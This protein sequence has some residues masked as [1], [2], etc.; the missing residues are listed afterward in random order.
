MIWV[1]HL[2]SLYLL[3]EAMSPVLHV[4]GCRTLPGSDV[5]GRCR[6]GFPFLVVFVAVHLV[7]FVVQSFSI[8]WCPFWV[9]SYQFL[10]PSFLPIPDRGSRDQK[11]TGY[12]IRNIG[13]KTYI[14]SFS[15][16]K[17]RRHPPHP[18]RLPRGGR[19]Q[20]AREAGLQG[21]VLSI[22][23]KN[24]SLFIRIDSWDGE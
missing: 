23:K 14:C 21:S 1:V 12:R 19:L 5:V 13:F 7:Y 6:T 15:L 17:A 18:V 24:N 11:G 9:L 2:W 16:D 8:L 20:E 10:D 4:E 3:L 22:R